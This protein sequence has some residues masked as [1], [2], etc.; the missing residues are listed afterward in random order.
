MALR[1]L[2]EKA[3]DETVYRAHGYDRAWVVFVRLYYGGRGFS[4]DNAEGAVAQHGADGSLRERL[5]K[6]FIV[7]AA[8]LP[9][10]LVFIAQFALAELRG[11][12]MN[13]AEDAIRAFCIE[14]S[15]MDG[16]GA[17]E[18]E[19]LR[20]KLARIFRADAS[21]VWI[22]LIRTDEYHIEW[23]VS[24]PVGE[25]MAGATFMGLSSAENQGRAKMSGVIVIAP[26]PP[27]PKDTEDSTTYPDTDT[28][29]E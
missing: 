27:P 28:N 15:Y 23:N 7:L 1:G 26:K 25:I 18:A 3:Q 14:A 17:G 6:Q 21:E 4:A 8:V 19:A 11:L 16:G 2:Q 9:I 5:M 13:A 10:L 29:P 22:E 20:H 24:F 12:R